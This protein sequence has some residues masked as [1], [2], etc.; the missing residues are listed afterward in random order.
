MRVGIKKRLEASVLGHVRGLI[1]G[2]KHLGESDIRQKFANRLPILGML[3]LFGLP[4]SHEVLLRSWYNSFEKALA[5]FT[6]D[7]GVRE[8]AK[9][10]VDE[11][12]KCLQV[13]IDNKR[14]T[15]D[16]SLLSQMIAVVDPREL[17]DEEIRRNASLTTSRTWK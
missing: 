6:W 1:D 14:R 3:S 2:F 12:H 15:P 16:D 5:N 10:N 4:A 11:F 17:S 7:E 9:R 8:T 13:Q